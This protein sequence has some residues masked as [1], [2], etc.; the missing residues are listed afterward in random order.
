VVLTQPEDGALLY[1][2]M[3]ATC[4]G[5]DGRG[6][7]PAA[8]ALKVPPTDLTTLSV[9]HGGSFPRD[10]V[11]SVLSGAKPVVAHGTGE[12]PVWSQRIEPRHTGASVGTALYMRRRL[13]AITDYLESI[14]RQP[15][16]VEP[17]RAGDRG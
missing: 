15:E 3:C 12:M 17:A 6:N 7:G 10:Y 5:L 14:Q 8:A 11:A 2:D 1:K 9:R 13:E 4:H 16:A